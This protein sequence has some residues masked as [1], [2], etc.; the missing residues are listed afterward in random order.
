MLLRSLLAG[1]LSLSLLPWLAPR[2][3]A[4]DDVI[5][6]EGIEFSNPDNQHLQLNLAQPK[7]AEGKLPAVVCI[8]GGGFRAGDRKDYNGLCKKLAARGYVA[9]TITYRLSPKYQFPAAVFD[10][11]AA[12]RWMK[13]NAE[14]YHVDPRRI[15]VLGGSA[16]G[17]LAQF[18]GVTGD[19]PRFE[20]DR[21]AGD[22]S[23]R[24]AC[25]V[26]YYGP[27]DFTKSYGKSVD[28]AQVLPMWLGGDLEHA[29]RQ[30]I[31]ASPLNWVTPDAAPTLLLHG[32]LDQYVAFEQ[33]EWMN[34]RLKA[35]DVE[36]KLVPLE[37]AK[38]GFGGKDAERAEKEAFEFLDAHL[39]QK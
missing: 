17:H 23:S 21:A 20:G 2:A 38:H 11:K 15:A 7:Q 6:E 36:V 28:A 4:A 8:H 34:D 26:N 10:C 18:M 31:L 19:V 13:I 25:V 9:A 16:G 37:G 33:A 24:I 30:H 35:C 14:K 12:I 3:R 1:L 32:T 39:K 22:P 29:R 27:S 5:F